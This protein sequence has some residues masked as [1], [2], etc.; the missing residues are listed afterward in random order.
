LIY[1]S[2]ENKLTPDELNNI[3]AVTGG[4]SRAIQARQV[5]LHSAD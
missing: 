1:R 5:L 4:L 2:S 3:S